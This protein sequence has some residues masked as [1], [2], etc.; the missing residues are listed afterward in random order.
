MIGG[1]PLDDVATDPHS[2]IAELRRQLEEQTAAH[3]SALAARDNIAATQKALLLAQQREALE[4][5]TATAE[6]LQVINAS[7][8]DLAPVFEAI[9]ERAHRVCGAVVGSLMTFDGTHFRAM[10]TRGLPERRAALVRRPFLPTALSK[11][12]VDGHRISHVWDL[13][14]GGE[15]QDDP[16]TRDLAESTDVRTCLMVP[17]RNK[18]KLLGFISGFRLEVRPFSDREI[19]LLENFAA[20]AMVAM[21]NARLLDELRGRTNELAR[22]QAELRI[23][24]ENMGDGV[25]LFDEN[26]RLVAWNRKFQELLDV[27]NGV[28]AER[29]TYAEYIRY[30]TERGEFG[31]GT[32]PETQLRR[33]LGRLGE[34]YTFERSRPDGRVLEIRQNPVPGG[35]IVLIY[36]D[37]TERKRNEEKILAARDAAEEASRIIEAAYS[38]IAVAKS[39]LEDAQ[40]ELETRTNTIIAMKE[41]LRLTAEQE[42][43]NKSRFMADAAHDLR[44]P[45]QA[46]SNFLEAASHAVN[47][48]DLARSAAHI[49]MSRVALSLTRTSFR[50]I[51]EISRLESGLVSFEESHFCVNT[52]VGEVLAQCQGLVRSGSVRIRTRR[53][54]QSEVVVKSDRHLLSRVLINLASNAVKYSDPAKGFAAWVIIGFVPF[55]THVRIDVADN[56]IGIPRERWNDIFLPFVQINNP[57]RDREKGVGLGLSI[58][59]AIMRILPEHRLNMNSVEGKG[60]RFSIE[61]PRSARTAVERFSLEGMSPGFPDV[62][63]AYIICIEDDKLV[64]ESMAAL[65]EAHGMLYE[66]VE[67]I[68]GLVR[69]GN[70]WERTPDVVIT[71]YRLPGGED[72]EKVMDVLRSRFS[73]PPPAIV[74]TG[75]MADLES[76]PWFHRNEMHLLRKPISPGILLAT[77]A[78]LLASQNRRSCHH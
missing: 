44:Q 19:A 12:L 17:L 9:L 23:I 35:G 30:L 66:L 75:E 76:E 70:R 77:I 1:T 31:P 14:A 46:L 7:P 49:E 20:Q 36:A 55:R 34:H 39:K 73:I 37:V 26:T 57:A 71:D 4:Q 67:S 40:V 8:G 72:A 54:Q 16:L 13:K 24:F 65:F 33:Y 42:N 59:N 41:Q 10:A 62:K 18:A 45:M 64:R 15:H 69:E 52:L 22:R 25:A 32:D 47:A 2:A 51:L 60:T 56:G 6:V 61:V 53:H 38:E 3:E 63:G 48:G 78:E 27:T 28:L 5:Q 50:E 29:L 11:P 21:E 58:V 74:L 68:D 43:A